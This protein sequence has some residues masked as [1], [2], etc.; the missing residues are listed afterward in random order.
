[1]GWNMLIRHRNGIPSSSLQPVYVF[2]PFA[3]RIWSWVEH[4]QRGRCIRCLVTLEI[5]KS[6]KSKWPEPPGRHQAIFPVLRTD[7]TT[8]VCA[9]GLVCSPCGPLFYENPREHV[10]MGGEE[11][12]N[13]NWQGVWG[14]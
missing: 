8:Y 3:F 9:A 12:G 1:M 13:C 10:K 6:K 4:M 11:A 14:P 2:L 7:F 5:E